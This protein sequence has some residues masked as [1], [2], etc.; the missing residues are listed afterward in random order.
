MFQLERVDDVFFPVHMTEPLE[1]HGGGRT[2][3]EG[4]HWNTRDTSAE[5]EVQLRLDHERHTV[6]WSTKGQPPLGRGC[7]SGF[8]PPS[9]CLHPL[10]LHPV[11]GD[12]ATK[13]TVAIDNTV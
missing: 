11:Y 1:K 9:S 7:L 13:L 3:R 5:V 8:R 12:A 2:D 10:L 6:C 4:M